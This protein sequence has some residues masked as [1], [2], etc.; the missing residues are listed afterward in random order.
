MYLSRRSKWLL[1]S[2]IYMV[3]KFPCISKF[4]IIHILIKA[5]H[6]RWKQLV[7]QRNRYKTDIIEKKWTKSIHAFALQ[8]DLKTFFK[9]TSS[10]K[11]CKKQKICQIIWA[12][13]FTLSFHKFYLLLFKISEGKHFFEIFLSNHNGK[14]AE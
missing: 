9:T 14:S 7:L 3:L 5:S 13:F 6:S 12:T 1:F 8:I 2:T 10:E 11:A 4:K